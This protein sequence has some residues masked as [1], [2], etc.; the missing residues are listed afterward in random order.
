[1][2]KISRQAAFLPASVE[3]LRE[4]HKKIFRK[5]YLCSRM[6]TT[7]S[8]TDMGRSDSFSEKTAPT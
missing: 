4:T 8:A 7:Y 3:E 5:K 1:M 6:E 2:A